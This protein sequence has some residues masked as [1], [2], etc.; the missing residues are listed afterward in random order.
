MLTVAL[1][2]ITKR[3]EN[4][5]WYIPSKENYSTI[6]IN[7]LMDTHVHRDESQKYPAK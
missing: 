1:F 3:I 2:I 5:V 6:K 4:K 7:E